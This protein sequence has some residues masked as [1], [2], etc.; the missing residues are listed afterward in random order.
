VALGVVCAILAAGRSS[1][2]GE[3]KAFLRV[4]A[5]TLLE[6]ALAA[7]AAYERV[8]A[9][10]AEFAARAA[11]VCAAAPGARPARVVPN[12][13]P[14]RGMTHS[15][16]LADAALGDPRAALVVLLVDT[17]LVDADLVARIVAARG[18]A[19][20]AYPERAGV[21]G[22]PVVFGPRP[23]VRL[24][25]LSDGDTLRALRAD[26]AWTRVAVPIDDDRPFLDLDTPA[27]AAALRAAFDAAEPSAS[28]P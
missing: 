15:L 20:V 23:R 27:D 22:H 4:G 26:P 3:P 10:G 7:S 28:E 19:D 1:R 17:P 14:E 12:D 13:A 21:R 11:E 8:V 18:D 9:I 6:R 16:R 2:M 25:T 24:A 5:A